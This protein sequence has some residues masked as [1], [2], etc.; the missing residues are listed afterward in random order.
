MEAAST[1]VLDSIRLLGEEMPALLALG[2]INP[3]HKSPAT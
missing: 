3:L 1:H 2:V